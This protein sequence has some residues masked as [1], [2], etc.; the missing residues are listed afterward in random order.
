M[1]A[2]VDSRYV[3]GIDAKVCKILLDR[4]EHYTAWWAVVISRK[5][6]STVLRATANGRRA[7]VSKY[8]HDLGLLFLPSLETF[9]WG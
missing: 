3:F 9:S 8:V 6:Q 5:E 1:I 4:A 2:Y 7:L